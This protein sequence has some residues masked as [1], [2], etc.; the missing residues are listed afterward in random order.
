MNNRVPQ[1]LTRDILP[2][3]DLSNLDYCFTNFYNLNNDL[4]LIRKEH[5]ARQQYP[6]YDLNNI[7]SSTTNIS[8]KRYKNL[9]TS[10]NLDA[11]KLF[12]D[13]R[14]N[15]NLLNENFTN[16]HKYILWELITVS[17]YPIESDATRGT[18]NIID[19]PA[20]NDASI[21]DYLTLYTEVSK[22]HSIIT[23]CYYE[24]N[25]TRW[26]SKPTVYV[27]KTYDFLGSKLLINSYY[28]NGISMKLNIKYQ[29]SFYHFID[30]SDIYLDISIPDRTPPTIIFNSEISFN[31]SV[32]KSYNDVKDLIDNKLTKDLSFIDL[33]QTYNITLAKAN[34]VYYDTSNGI[35][36]K[37][38][39]AS[40]SLLEIDLTD[41][42]N[43][44]FS[45]NIAFRA[46]Y[47][48]YSIVDN[49]NNRNV[50][51]RLVK[52]YKGIDEP[53]FI[54]KN[55]LYFSSSER[56]GDP[57]IINEAATYETFFSILRNSVVIANPEIRT[58][59][60]DRLVFDQPPIDVSYI[61]IDSINIIDNSANTDSIIIQYRVN[62]QILNFYDLMN[63]RLIV[64]SK[65]ND[66]FLEYVSSTNTYSKVGRFKIKLTIEP[67]QVNNEVIDPHC[68]YPKVEYKPI[69]DNYKLGSQNSTVMRMAKY[70]INRNV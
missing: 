60:P 50:I 53:V 14:Y 7:A 21:N 67:T 70:I 19:T 9:F 41:V 42:S 36:A 69:Q 30:L 39:N 32:F 37:V 25:T 8:L 34:G 2:I 11:A 52:V 10:N 24:L 28:S 40:F 45:N 3:T 22:L 55:R 51:K 6:N 65:T 38:T 16:D 43:L 56:Q 17:N 57:L 15:F 29:K 18:N 64:A 68:C 26:P 33:N 54:Y 49:A 66:L 46:S 4:D 58:I 13:L 1:L 62:E 35:I 12:D 31:E 5:L 61:D 20:Y 47:I 44:A 27:K 48:K 63:N 59:Y 23:F